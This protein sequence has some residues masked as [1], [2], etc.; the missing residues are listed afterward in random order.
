MANYSTMIFTFN[1]SA[2]VGDYFEIE[3]GGA[4]QI[5]DIAEAFVT[6]RYGAN[7]SSIQGT[8]T[9]DA[10][11]LTSALIT[12]YGS[13]GR[14][15]IYQNGY[16]VVVE[17][18]ILNQTFDDTDVTTGGRVSVFITNYGNEV[19]PITIDSKDFSEAST[20]P[21]EQVNVDVTT[22]VLAEEYSIEDSVW[23]LNSN[24]PFTFSIPRGTKL[25]L[26][27]KDIDGNEN[28]TQVIAP[29]ILN[30]ATTTIKTSLTPSGGSVVI[31]HTSSEGLD[32]EYSLDG[33]NWKSEN[34]FTGLVD[35]NY[36]LY[37]KDQFGCSFQTSFFIS[38]YTPDLKPTKPFTYIATS[39][40]IRYKHNEVWDN[41]EIFK[42]DDN[43]LACEE[44]AIT[45]TP[46]L[47]IF[48]TGRN[49]TTQMLS[50][51]EEIEVNVI[52]EDGSKEALNVVKM[53]SFL[54]I[55]DKRQANVY[56]YSDTQVGVYFTSGNLYDYVSGV[57]I[58][59]YELNGSLPNY[60]A[61]G[62]AIYI[63]LLGGWFLITSIATDI[64]KGSTV[65]LVDYVYE[66]EDIVDIVSCE[67]NQ[68]N[69]NVYE[70]VLETSS[71][72]KETV[73]IEVLQKSVLFG[74][75]NYL[76]EKLFITD[77]LFNQ[78]ELIWYNDSDTYVYYSTGIK[79][80]GYPEFI[81]FASGNSGNVEIHKTPRSAVMIESLNYKTKRLVLEELPT[82]LMQLY[83]QAVIH[84]E[85][86]INKVKYVGDETT[87]TE[88][89]RNTN[90]Y[91]FEVGLTKTG[92][93]FNSEWSG[94]DQ[95][96]GSVELVGLLKNNDKYIKLN[97]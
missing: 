35:G 7:E 78:K 82:G 18:L 79:N 74:T 76:S 24:N 11:N 40:S 56:K 88:N 27:V 89:I 93:V 10:Y 75:Y 92:E 48:K 58:G 38:I 84:K 6:R 65:L 42:T 28:R 26:T 91:S 1:A 66:G 21:C 81:S 68:K 14:Y 17:S 23:V 32:I 83:S 73:Q 80:I 67:Y 16:T 50:N 62:N 43:T 33:I 95:Q 51:Y 9:G 71:Y 5:V 53:I 52:K 41:D 90:V 3:V 15:N 72:L 31:T 59:T 55:Q 39:M 57:E 44:E 60:G 25:F 54:N 30:L 69:Y 2:E 46:A 8:P 13:S 22:S 49:V 20:R 86:Y 85:L 37:V 87:E 97:N 77:K 47:Q 96:T 36:D 45:V 94:E 64:S 29:A 4:G 61:V 70:F 63:P 12:D 19:S 34:T